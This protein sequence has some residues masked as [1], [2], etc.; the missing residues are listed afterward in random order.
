MRLNLVLL[1]SSLI[2]I[3]GKHFNGGTINWAPV[4]PYSNSTTVPITI[5]QTYSWTFPYIR[6]SNNVPTSTPGWGS[7]NR[8]LTCVVDCLTDGG[9]ST[10]PVDILTDCTSSSTSLSMLSSTKTKNLTL[11]AGAH[12]YLAY[13]GT[14]WVSLNFPPQSGLEWSIVTF[15]DLR[16]RPDGFINTPPVA[17]V[18]SPQYAFVN[19]TLQIQ[20]PVSDANVGDDVRCRWAEY[21]DGFRKKKRSNFEEFP[22]P[23]SMASFI[24]KPRRAT[25][26]L[27]IRKK[28]D[29]NDCGGWCKGECDCTC[30]VCDDTNCGGSGEQ[31]ELEP[32]CYKLPTTT[33]RTTTSQPVTTT[34]TT[35]RTTTTTAEPTTTET[36]GTL[37]STSSFPIRQAIDECGGI[38]YPGSLPNGTTLSNCAITFTG[39]RAGVWYAVAIQVRRLFILGTILHFIPYR[40]KISSTVRA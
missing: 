38:C 13:L 12:F 10:K 32:G 23:E 11:N 18:I 26:F 24:E 14:A 5:T 35:T 1:L 19:Q 21:T 39:T 15:I 34:T 29:C 17:T 28:R 3:E 40:L 7:A 27:H 6:C 9:Y 20:I 36:I 16:M 37:K 25:E 33:T 22:V 31:C 2:N 4:N 8:N 30:S